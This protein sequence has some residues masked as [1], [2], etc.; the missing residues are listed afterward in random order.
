MGIA[1]FENVEVYNLSFATTN[2]GEL[3]TTQALKFTS[4]PRVHQVKSSLQISEKYRVYQGLINFT[5]GYTPYTKAMV[6]DQNLYSI[7]WSGKDY[8]ID[9]ATESD[10][11]MS[12]TFLC[13]HND[14]ETRV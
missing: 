13:Y 2:F 6:D 4:R 12:V 3:Q 8:R 5:F 14:P 1:R 7:K 9:S 11:R 10:D